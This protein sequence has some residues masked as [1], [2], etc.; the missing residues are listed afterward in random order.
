MKTAVESGVF[1]AWRIREYSVPADYLIRTR[2][3]LMAKNV[4][5]VKQISLSEMSAAF[6]LYL[7]GVA[8]SGFWMLTEYIGFASFCN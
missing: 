7:F 3:Q 2:S 8:I 5:N 6:W 4:E 1:E